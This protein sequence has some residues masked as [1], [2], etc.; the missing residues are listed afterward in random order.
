MITELDPVLVNQS[1]GGGPKSNK[2]QYLHMETTFFTEPIIIK[3]LTGIKTGDFGRYWAA[4][5]ST[6]RIYPICS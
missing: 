3:G 4:V 5:H 2:D 1:G 6:W